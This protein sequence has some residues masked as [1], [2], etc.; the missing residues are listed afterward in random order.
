MGIA[1]SSLV[2]LLIAAQATVPVT[3]TVRD[4][5][6]GAPLAEV[7]VSLTSAPRTVM[8]DEDGR[9]TLEAPPGTQHVSVQRFGYTPQA[10]D[11]LVPSEG[12]LEINIALRRE[13][14][15][16]PAIEVRAPVPIR[17]FDHA[18]G[19]D[20]PDRSM[21]QS[22]LYH[23]PFT[24]EP[25]ALRALGG[26]E[27]NLDPESPS[28]MHIRGG[29]SDQVAYLLDGIPI[30]NPY[31]T[32]GTFAAWNP[33]ALA[34]IDLVAASPLHSAPDVLSGVVS[35]NTR[36]PGARFQTRGSVSATQARATVDGPFGNTG[37]GYLAS[38]GSAFPGLAMHKDEPSHM[39]GHNFDWIG[40]L[41]SPLLGGRVRMLGY[42]SQTE[43]GVSA[44]PEVDSAVVDPFR[45]TMDWNGRSLG[46]EWG[47]PI[48]DHAAL[49]LRGWTASGN[50]NATWMGPDSLEWL[51]STQRDD[52]AV[53]EFAFASFGGTTT[54]GARFQRIETS[55]SLLPSSADGRATSFESMT[56]IS[57]V[58]LE[59]ERAV[60]SRTEVE[61]SFASALAA[62]EVYYSP[63]AQVR[64]RASRTLLLSVTGARR[65]QFAQSLRNS[66]SVVSNVFPPDL[67][68][69]AGESGI[70]VASSDIGIVALEHRPNAWL[71]LGAQGYLRDF[72]SLA[73]VAPRSADPYATDGFAV[74]AGQSHGFSLE[75]GA[76]RE[77][78]GALASY[79][80]QQVKLQHAGGSYAPNY[81]PTHSFQAGFVLTP[82]S[83]YTF[84]LG[85]EG[86]V[87]RRTTATLGS[88]E[89]EACNLI[90][91]GCEFAGNPSQ[92]SGDLGGTELPTYL[93]LDFG[94]RKH[95]DVKF[96]GRDGTVALFGTASNLLARRNV[97]TVSVNPETGQRNNIDMMP[98]SPLVVGIDW[99][100]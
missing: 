93:R 68:L 6:S 87:G 54:T 58:F 98:P 80:Y 35:A 27:V 100:F 73:L 65:H 51:S 2:P 46:A 12:T 4:A 83:S 38:V 47:R 40:K 76:S 17:G 72:D 8:T 31:H 63:S 34:S 25:D 5:D 92:W 15:L 42:G 55:Y 60:S 74:D 61:V 44:V 26:G 39:N 48:G 20:F 52:G 22:D 18:R 94:V 9:Y 89:W 69:G 75:A 79:T 33:D 85:L 11:A 36:A 90:D 78:F 86:I 29:A 59:H 84:R 99:R 10:F 50:A 7:I 91:G 62:S 82:S 66:E 23:H 71:R 64:W 97:L 88:F 24:A 37:A 49:V 30:F 43:V 14:I 13:P 81:G 67:Y 32:G 57:T 16:L 41:E 45:N 70:P 96:A 77:T 56:P 53:A 21:S 95:W 3:G 1:L 19:L 28:G